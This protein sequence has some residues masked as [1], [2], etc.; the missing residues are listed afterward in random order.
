MPRSLRA[1]GLPSERKILGQ[2][3]YAVRTERERHAELDQL[4]KQAIQ[5][6]ESLD[7]RGANEALERVSVEAAFPRDDTGSTELHDSRTSE[8]RNAFAVTGPVLDGRGNM[9]SG[10]IGRP[11]RADALSREPRKVTE[12]G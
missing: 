4:L 6:L 11:E 5:C 2:S 8:A 3:E 10:N 7:L 1:E 12:V 9:A